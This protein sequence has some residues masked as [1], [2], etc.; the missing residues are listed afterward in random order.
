MKKR[1][2]MVLGMLLVLL[3]CSCAKKKT[4]DNSLS[5]IMDK[6]EL[7]V[8]L[9]PSFPPMGFTDGGETIGFDIDLAKEV[10]KRMGITLKLQ[11]VDWTAKEL[12]LKT[13]NIDCI[14]NGLSYSEERA[15]NMTL[16]PSYMLN[17]QVIVVLKDSPIQSKKDLAGKIVVV[18]NGSTASEAMEGKKELVDSLKEYIKVKD[19]VQAMM[20]L[21]I[22]GSDAVVMDEVVAKYYVALEPD[23]YR[24]LEDSM[25]DEK[26]VVGFRK[27]DQALCDEIMKQLH[28]MKDDKTLEKIAT[29]WFGEDITDL[30]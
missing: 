27:G 3:C 26:F 4:G 7:I 21:K 8:G 30:Q 11:P 1:Y 2:F 22:S 6:K 9:D 24:V 13:K 20:D 28:A 17:R 23:T 15:E 18:Q 16:S 19:N 29:E 10:C 5:Y 25:A 12:E 14:W